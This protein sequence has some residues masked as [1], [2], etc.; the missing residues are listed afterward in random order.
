MN[1]RWN[2]IGQHFILSR[3]EHEKILA[4]LDKGAKQLVLRNGRLGMNLASPYLFNET[5]ELTDE[6]EEARIKTMRLDAPPYQSPSPE[7]IE[8][9]R[10]MNEEF[11]K[12]MGWIT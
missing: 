10:K 7:D 6:Q 3:E 12:K 2:F 5:N 4:A 9:R 11:K 1:Y 8:R